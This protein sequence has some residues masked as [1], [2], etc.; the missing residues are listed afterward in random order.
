MYKNKNV[1][2]IG[3]GGVSM[4]GIAEMLINLGA[5]VTGSDMA[6]SKITKHL[7][8]MGIKIFYGHYPEAI[9]NADVG[10][11]TA[12]ISKDVPE[13]LKAQELKKELYE[14][15]EFL[16]QLMTLYKNRICISGTHGKSTTTGMIS[17][18]F[19]EAK[20][21]PTIQIGAIL[22]AI[23]S[24]SH[25][26]SK[27][28]LIMEACEYVD[29]FLHFLPTA[30]VV[31][32]IDNDHLDYFKNLDNIKKSFN[33]Y[34]SLLPKDG[35][36]IVN[37]D[38]QN[39]DDLKFNTTGKVITY[40]IDKESDFQAINIKVD[41]EGFY[42]FDILKD[43]A[44]FLSINLQIKGFHNVYNALAAIAIA[45]QYITNV[46]FFKEGIESYHGVERRFE[47]IGTYHD[48]LIYDDYAHHPTEMQTTLET[49]NKIVHKKTFAIFQP[50]TYS[51]TKEHMDSF[52]Q[53]L[54][55]FDEVIIAKIYPARETDDLGISGNTLVDAINKLGGN[56]V[57]INNFDDIVTYLKDKLMPQD[58]A[59]TIGA[60]PINEV[61]SKLKEK[62]K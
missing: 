12:A 6:E 1:H 55:N 24:T 54:K 5:C 60:G 21:N 17:S 41:D 32:N 49:L 57:Y 59:I 30:E 8:Q 35:Y 13:R 45:S 26:G 29:S 25:I 20:L 28:Y 56:A 58:I 42:S 3:I 11:Y 18:I 31:T 33:K 22:P 4:S 19:L 39:S 47:Y 34:A 53:I 14:R 51:R 61:A 37:N 46:D 2:L 27:D 15:A 52:A 16:G 43:N 38:N 50:H 10:G 48:A 7:E 44:Q 23:N 62:S 36:L 40:G 9:K